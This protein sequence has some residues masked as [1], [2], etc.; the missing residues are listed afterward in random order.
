MGESR[1]EQRVQVSENQ[2]MLGQ[3]GLGGVTLQ[4][5]QPRLNAEDLR[6]RRIGRVRD[7]RRRGVAAVL[8]RR[9]SGVAVLPAFRSV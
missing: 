9:R 3:R 2:A 4:R 8:G 1:P 6:L 7:T 5:A